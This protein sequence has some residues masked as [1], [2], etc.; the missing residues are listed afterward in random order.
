MH[1]ARN[2]GKRTVSLYAIYLGVPGK[3]QKNPTP[4]DAFVKSPGN[5]ASDIR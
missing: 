3:W 2:E 5:C 1:L 4:L